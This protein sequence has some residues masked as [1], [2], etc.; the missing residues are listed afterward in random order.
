[1]RKQKLFIAALA[2]LAG[3]HAANAQVAV[4]NGDFS[5]SGGS[6]WTLV[7]GSF[8]DWGGGQRLDGNAEFNQTIGG[9]TPGWYKVSVNGYWR[10]FS[11]TAEAEIQSKY[12]AY[13]NGEEGSAKGFFYGNDTEKALVSYLA[14]TI[15]TP[16][17][18]TDAN[19]MELKYNDNSV[20]IPIN[21]VSHTALFSTPS[22]YYLNELVCAVGEDGKLT[23]GVKRTGDYRVFVDNFT[24]EAVGCPAEIAQA[25]LD[26]ADAVD[27]NSK[28]DAAVQSALTTAINNFAADASY[29][30][31]KALE[32]AVKDANANIIANTLK[33]GDEV[34]VPNGD[35]AATSAWTLVSGS[36]KA[37]GSGQ[38]FDA[39]FEFKQ[40]LKELPEGWYK[41]TTQAYARTVNSAGND[42][43][44]QEL[45][46]AYLAG[47]DDCQSFFYGNDTEKKIYNW[48][49][50]TI[51]AEV[52]G[53][54]VKVNDGYQDWYLPSNGDSHTAT[55]AN[56][57]YYMNELFCYVGADGNLTIGLKQKGGYRTFCKN[58]TVTYIGT[59]ALQSKAAIE[60]GESGYATF[61]APFDVVLPTGVEA[62]TV[63]GVDEDG[64]TLVMQSVGATV[65]ANTPVVLHSASA[66]Y[67][68]VYGVDQATGIFAEKGLLTGMYE[69]RTLTGGYVLQ[70]QGD[71]AKFYSVSK[72]D[73]VTV[74]ANHAFLTVPGGSSVKAF[75]FSDI[76]TAIE[77]L[78]AT[79]QSTG[80]A[81]YNLQGQRLGS[82]QRVINVV[83]GKKVL[84]K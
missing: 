49:A 9:V 72:T 80:D 35:F 14:S 78:S 33:P 79:R 15:T 71:G 64:Q 12:E 6:G 57:E 24:V 70:D 60:I 50:G 19:F 51:A 59:E 66:V 31:Y 8:K 43:L 83:G 63:E 81:I 23:I 13:K 84:I 10:S 69:D 22:T 54:Y 40:T 48:N 68:P 21:G 7:T 77:N 75:G 76:V 53:S 4:V 26:D 61:V 20:Y 62:F 65:A 45:F 29:T 82:L 56:P 34:P 32:Q 52:G 1:M 2:L 28:M 5:E 44:Q 30:N 25:L 74:P 67:N 27:G 38:R 16:P 58:F 3:S 39:N 36:W 47:A 18:V 11:N 46:D 41:V 17:T 37:W 55:F 42:A 73:K